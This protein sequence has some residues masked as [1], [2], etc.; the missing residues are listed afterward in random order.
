MTANPKAT[1]DWVFHD[2]NVGTLGAIACSE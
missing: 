1:L 2:A